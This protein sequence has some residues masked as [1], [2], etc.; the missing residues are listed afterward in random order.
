MSLALTLASV[1]CCGI[2]SGVGCWRVSGRGVF[3]TLGEVRS[4]ICSQLDRRDDL[5]TDRSCLTKQGLQ[6]QHIDH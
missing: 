3:S 2:M 5:I 6:L 4:L 1:Y